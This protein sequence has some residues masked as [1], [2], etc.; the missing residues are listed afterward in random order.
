MKSKATTEVK[1]TTS[2]IPSLYTAWD[3]MVASNMINCVLVLMTTNIT[4]A[5]YIKQF[6]LIILELITHM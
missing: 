4:Q 6:L 2:Y 3:Q 5:F 1:N